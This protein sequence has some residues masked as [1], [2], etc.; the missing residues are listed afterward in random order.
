MGWRV[1]NRIRF[2]VEIVRA[3][4]RRSAATFIIIYR[5]SMLDLVDGGSTW[6]EVVALAQA[7][8]AAG[9]RSSTPVSAGTRRDPDDR[10]DGAA[11]GLCLGDATD[12]RRGAIPLI[13]TNRDQRSRV[14]E[15]VHR[16]RRRRH[17]VD[18]APF[19]ADPA[20]V[21]KAAAG[22]ADE[23]NTCIGCN[24]ACLDHIFERQIATC[25][26]NPYACRE[27]S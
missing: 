7:V 10:D 17:G 11:R 2:A 14:A 15:A 12:E 18:G 19:L 9:R 1:R 5:L 20:F 24:Q 13:T 4:A 25:L 21:A 22:R 23:I 8:E 27:T 16:A 3:R 26:V 6:D